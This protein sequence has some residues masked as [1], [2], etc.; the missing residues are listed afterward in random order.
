M[1]AP[2]AGLAAVAMEAAGPAVLVMIR[3]SALLLRRRRF[4]AC[5]GAC[6]VS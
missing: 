6:D 1:T 5:G 3:L 4:L 2:C